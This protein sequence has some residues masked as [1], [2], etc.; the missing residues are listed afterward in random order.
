[1]QRISLQ[2]TQRLAFALCCR[3]LQHCVRK[4]CADNRS[5]IV[6]KVLVQSECHIAG[7]ATE[8]QH[9]SIFPLQDVP[10]PPCRPPPPQAVYI[11]RQHMIQH[12][13]SRCYRREHLAYSIRSSVLIVDALRPCSY[14]IRLRFNHHLRL[15]EIADLF[16]R[17]QHRSLWH[18]GFDLNLA[19]LRWQNEMHL[20]VHRLLISAQPFQNSLA[21]NI[22]FR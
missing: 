10:E 14:R 5:T 17:L 3:T 18:I 4:I 22:H 9:S 19:Y 12:V 16:H 21:A 15:R 6:A 13:V 2:P 11:H 8:I 7:S 20:T 1:L